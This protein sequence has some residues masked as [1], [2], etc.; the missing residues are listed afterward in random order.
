MD[1]NSDSK[2]AKIGIL[3]VGHGSR[4]P[5]GKDVVSQLAE[6]YKANSDY[7]VEVGFMNISKPS[8]PSAINKLAKEGVGKIIVTPVFLAHGVHTKQDIPHILGLD[9]G[10]EHSHGH[11]HG[12]SHDDEEEQE[13]IEFEGEIIYTEPLGAD[14]RLVDIIKDR[15]SSA[16]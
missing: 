4:L 1:T 14:A 3:L 6:M 2:T 15:V 13:E 9:G 16:L 7:L 8:I 11:D 5:Y 12:H 10:H